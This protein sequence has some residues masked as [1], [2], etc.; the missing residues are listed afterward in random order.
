MNENKDN[1]GISLSDPQVQTAIV[2][3]A[4]ETLMFS[5]Q[6]AILQN[7]LEQCIAI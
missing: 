5:D 2:A 1:H 4:A 7:I 6:N 3:Q